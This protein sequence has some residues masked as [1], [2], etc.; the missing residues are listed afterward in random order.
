MMDRNIGFEQRWFSS[1]FLR[2]FIFQRCYYTKLWNSIPS[3]GIRHNSQTIIWALCS[4]ISHSEVKIG[5]NGLKIICDIAIAYDNGVKD[6][7]FG[8]KVSPKSVTST[9]I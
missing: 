5:K 6:T 7:D 2:N 4:T 9:K 1:I 8:Y 3:L